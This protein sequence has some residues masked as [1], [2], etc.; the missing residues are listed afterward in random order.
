MSASDHLSP[1]QFQVREQPETRWGL[2]ALHVSA[3]WAGKDDRGRPVTQKVGGLSVHQRHGA[4]GPVAHPNVWVNEEHQRKGIA[5][6][7]YAQVA[8]H[9]P[10]VPIVHSE[11]ASESAKALNRTLRKGDHN[12]DAENR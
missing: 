2:P 5:T 10:D 11:H 8:Q 4:E 1:Y 12:P 3:H 7:M 6:E 9:W